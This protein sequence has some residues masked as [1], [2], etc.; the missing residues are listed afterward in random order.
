METIYISG[1]V[2]GDKDYRKKFYKASKK[3]TK[4]GFIES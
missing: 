2:T 4:A 3:L 1:K